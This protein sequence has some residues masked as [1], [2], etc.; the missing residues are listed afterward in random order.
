MNT[1]AAVSTPAGA[2]GIGIIRVSGKD[3]RAIADAVFVC[4][5]R[6]KGRGAADALTS[7]PMTMIFG[8]FVAEDF[9]D[10]GYAVFFP[11]DRAYTGEDTVEF[12]LHGGVRIMRGAL[13]ECLKKGARA[14]ERGE[15]TRRA[16]LAGRMDLADAEGVADMIN[17]ESAA[18]LR[19]AYR[20]MDGSVSRRINL[21]ADRLLS[22]MTGLEAVL[23]YP[24]ETEDEVLPPLEGSVREALADTQALLATAKSG[25]MA[26]HG[27]TAVLT[28]KPNAGKSSLFNALL[29]DDRAI[30]TPVAG[31]TRDTVEGSVECDGVRINFVD[32]AGLRD[33]SDA[34]ESEGI[35]RARKAAAHA[36]VV[37]RVVDTVSEGR[38]GGE[39]EDYD[40]PVFTV[41]NKC[42]LTSYA[43][44]RRAGWFAVS[45][46]EGVG[47]PEL[48]RAIASLMGEG[49]TQGGEL[50]TSERHISALYRAKN[51]LEAALRG[52]NDTPDCIL[53]CLREAYDALGEITGSTA[54][55]AVVD[56]VFEK[57][58]VGK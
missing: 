16:F 7:L 25:R 35:A 28:G 36:D 58:C 39:H 15:F 57:F 26:K 31:T 3:A 2:G 23:D 12:Y 18:G 44:P 50:I 14:A 8:D 40:A 22:V 43:C 38:G 45:A 47:V 20:L 41:L 33:S 1:I 34:V 4:R 19:A 46:K 17:A 24:E 37:L 30:V 11:A 56:S 13:E 6:E 29:G 32:T 42:D 27:I 5:G 9:R 54:T 53:L 51:A 49:L 10:R 21:I 52:I 48:R 55:Q